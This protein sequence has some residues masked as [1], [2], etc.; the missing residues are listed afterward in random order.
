MREFIKRLGPG[1]KVV[2]IFDG[3]ANHLGL[4]TEYRC[5][6]EALAARRDLEVTLVLPGRWAYRYLIA[7]VVG[8]VEQLGWRVMTDEL[9]THWPPQLLV[10]D[11]GVYS[12]AL[13]DDKSPYTLYDPDNAHRLWSYYTSYCNLAATSTA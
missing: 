11:D 1:A 6:L 3:F 10:S 13:F 9:V 8:D 7:G 5:M 12:G 4:G 2:V